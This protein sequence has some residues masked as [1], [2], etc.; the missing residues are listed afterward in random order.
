MSFSPGVIVVTSASQ[1]SLG[2]ADSKRSFLERPDLTQ[3]GEKCPSQE[4]A[5]LFYLLS[6]HDGVASVVGFQIDKIETDF[7][8]AN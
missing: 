5:E 7:L 2:E 1:R 8:R 6:S 3:A 4:C